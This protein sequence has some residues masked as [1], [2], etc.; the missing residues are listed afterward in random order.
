MPSA[1]NVL[2]L[3]HPGEHGLFDPW[4][5]DVVEL[6]SARHNLRQY[7]A[8]QPMAPQFEN[9]D[10]V[11]D[12]GGSA[13][14]TEMADIA[15]G[16][17]KL[18][19]I[20]GQGTDHFDLEYWRNKNIPVSNCPG[21]FSA[22]ALSECAMMFILMLARQ[23]QDCRANLDAGGFY[24]PTASGLEGLKLSIIGFGASGIELAK[25]ALPFGLELHAV[26]VRTIDEVEIRKYGLKSAVGAERM[27]DLIAS[28]DFVSVHLHLNNET[29][30]IIDD[31]RIRLMK[32]TAF[33]VNVARGELVDESALSAALVEGRIGGAGIDV[34]GQE[35]PDLSQPIFQMPN[36][37]ITP[38][39]AG[40]TKVT[41]RNRAGAAAENVD[42][43]AN[44]LDP[45]YRV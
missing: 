33:L 9:I 31:R 42:R 30:H 23:Y 5:K 34:F 3:P 28:S 2:F 8:D 41:S 17:V 7:D 13:G 32:P 45:L 36:V 27:D 14:T 35:P 22:A 19:Q 38:H 39:I 1:I 40:S 29:R 26:D 43:I 12:H 18:W 11:V 24:E 10:V 6:V 16:K 44:G 4:G 20:L 21:Q 37:V 25:R 15:A